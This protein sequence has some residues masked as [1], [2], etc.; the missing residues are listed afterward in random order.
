MTKL[1]EAHGG[2]GPEDFILE[3]LKT[4]APQEPQM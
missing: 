1:K 2:G 3:E 4:E